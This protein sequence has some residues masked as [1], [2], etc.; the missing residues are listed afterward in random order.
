MNNENIRFQQPN[1]CEVKAYFDQWHV[2]D[3]IMQNDYMAH[4]GIH[5]A[6]REK[7]S[8]T[9][10]SQF[11][12]LDLGCGDGSNISKTLNGLQADLYIGVDL[13]EVALSEAKKVFAN[14]ELNT[15]FV[16]SELSEYLSNLQTHKVDVVIAG[17][18]IHHLTDNDKPLILQCIYD[19]LAPGGDLFFYDVFR[20]GKETRE[21]YLDKYCEWMK[22]TWKVL[23]F[24]Q[25]KCTQE[26]VK[27]CDFPINYEE[28][29]NFAL[30]AGFSIPS[31]PIFSDSTGFHCLCHLKKNE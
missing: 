9:R 8:S 14:S 29:T 19:K 1:N 13:S 30:Q 12:V 26:H 20:R 4:R 17:F 21:Q 23:S 28:L 31:S 2:Y 22:N 10:S 18:A 6:L 15:L 11:T 25:S 5:K 7:L 24:E 3:L 27:Q 16:Q